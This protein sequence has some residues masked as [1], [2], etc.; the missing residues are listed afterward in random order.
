MLQVNHISKVYKTGEFV[1]RALDD[2]TLTLRDNEFVAVLGPSGS[3]KTTLLN[4]IGG[5]DRYDSGDLIINNVSTKNYKDRDWDAY[6]N[7][8]VGFV[9]Q[10]YNLIPH[11]SVVANVELALTISGVSRGERRKRALDA[12]EQVGLKEHAH[13]KPN[14]LSGGQMQRVALARALVNDPDILL[15]DEPTGALDSETSLQVMDLLQEVAKDRLVVMVTHNKQLAKNYATRIVS[16][17]DGRIV[18]DTDPV[19]ATTDTAAEHKSFGRS[20]MSFVAALQLSFNNLRTKFGRS[21]LTSFA[22]SIGIIGIALIIALSSGVK[23]YI[24]EVQRSTMVSYPVEIQ[25]ETFDTQVYIGKAPGPEDMPRD[26]EEGEATGVRVDT[27]DLKMEEEFRNRLLKNNMEKFKAYLDDPTSE[28]HAYI[29]ENGITYSYATK[30]DVYSYDPDGVLLNT[31]GEVVNGGSDTAPE[32][33]ETY[34]MG[35]EMTRQFGEI[36]AGKDG[37]PVSLAVRD[38]YELVAGDWPADST[39]VVLVLNQ[40][41]GLPSEE[42]FNLGILP[43]ATYE[44][45]QQ[46]IEDGKGIGHEF[47]EIDYATVIGKSFYLLP[48]ALT[49]EE[50]PDGTFAKLTDSLNAM[51]PLLER[52]FELKV[53]GIVRPVEDAKYTPLNF[54]VGYLKE[55]TDQIIEKTNASAVVQRQ[56][57]NP[58]TNVFSGRP[59][60]VR[61]DAAKIAA[62]KDYF[63]TLGITD[64]A[65]LA[66]NV[67]YSLGRDIPQNLEETDKADM[68]PELLELMP[69]KEFIMFYDLQ[70]SGGTYEDNIKELGVVSLDNPSGIRIYTDRFEDKEQ[71]T[72]CIDDYNSKVAEKDRIGYVDLIG[73]ILNSVTTVINIVSMVLIAFVAVSLIVSSIMIGIITYISVLERTKEI[74]ILRAIGASKRN[75]KQVFNAET[76]LVGLGAGIIGVAVTLLLQIPVNALLH[77]LAGTDTL[78]ANLPPMQAILLV[79]LSILLTVIGGLIPAGKAAKQDPVAALRSE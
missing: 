5:L 6:R 29:G 25:S 76:F 74:G 17:L 79:G 49:F 48:R 56:Q 37:T 9:F 24:D 13:K 61:D 20:A 32:D 36:M 66:M 47:S 57:A 44:E 71:I 69:D 14:Q 77:Q 23:D 46:N 11:Q 72:R 22:G 55:L 60:E 21:A 18:G 73:L 28:I 39:E 59:F 12:L 38:N 62:A 53:A 15:A 43:H 50:Q 7:H 67:L 8:T 30:F 34:Y 27:S 16:L 35:P 4:I 52:G 70:L 33:E 63:A 3:G 54:H 2:V 64:K 51:E 75:I 58:D 41:N 19:D 26:A 40:A 65:Q 78:N 45:I 31:R 68:L 10:S 1:Q 42:L